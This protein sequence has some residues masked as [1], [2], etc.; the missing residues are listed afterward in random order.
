M[1]DIKE[2]D[3]L[4]NEEAYKKQ[5]K[6]KINKHSLLV[7]KA[8]L[9]LPSF[10]AIFIGLILIFPKIQDDGKT[11]LLDV[12]LPKKGELEKLHIEDTE[13]NITDKNNRVHNFT[14]K[15]IDETS[16]GS[17]LIKL[18]NPDGIMPISETDW[19]NI[20]SPVGY[21][22][23]KDNIIELVENVQIYHSM[24]I[25]ME[26]QKIDYNFQT[27]IAQSNT[28]VFGQGE[29]GELTSEGFSFDNNTGIITF[30]GKTFI[31]LDEKFLKGKPKND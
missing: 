29:M 11:F 5:E 18:I 10:A 13:L 27:N 26:T 20:K 24:G 7:K 12:T 6:Q 19:I 9:I 22:N 31:K 21:Y 23:Q 30:K 8:K 28:P 17:K 3:S 4:F 14:A 15:N 16:P 25:N 2:I 1:V